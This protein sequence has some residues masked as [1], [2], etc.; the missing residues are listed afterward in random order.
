MTTAVTPDS[1]SGAVPILVRSA[2]T[3]SGIA[4]GSADRGPAG[5]RFAERL[6]QLREQR[7][8]LGQRP[9]GRQRHRRPARLLLGVVA[10]KDG[11][12]GTALLVDL[13]EVRLRGP[14]SGAAEGFVDLLRGVRQ[15]GREH[16]VRAVSYTH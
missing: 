13:H 12:R 8:G 2:T 10:G 11:V 16:R 6:V 5:A 14:D 9:A 3:K 1:H 4:I 7:A 15:K